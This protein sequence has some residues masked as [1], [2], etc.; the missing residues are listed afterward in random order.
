M[1]SKRKPLFDA[2]VGVSADHWYRRL[3]GADIYGARR[4][5]PQF[6]D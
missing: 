6:R 1:L 2:A 4:Q 3:L 5:L